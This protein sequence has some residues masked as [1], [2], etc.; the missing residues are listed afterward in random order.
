MKKMLIIPLSVLALAAC[1]GGGA[2]K[3]GDGQITADEAK[4]EMDGG[5]DIAMRAG[6]WE[7]EI[8]FDDIEITGMPAEAAAMMRKHMG[9][10]I[11][12]RAC[13]TEEDV[14][15][16]GSD[17][18][19]GTND[20]N[21]TLD[22]FDRD[23]GKM[24]VAMTCQP[25]KGVTTKSRMEGRFTPDSYVMTMS[26]MSEGMPTGPVSMKGKI[27]GRYIGPCPG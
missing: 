8:K 3:D 10:G 26:Q 15:E 16:P 9:G 25:E 20:A 7:T 23:G 5:I 14:K 4:A 17:F 2:D 11:T 1:G 12:T 27:E 18:F 13:L 19:G 22:E 21:C 24:T 6:Q